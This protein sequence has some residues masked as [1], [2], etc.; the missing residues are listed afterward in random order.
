MQLQPNTL[1]QLDIRLY[2]PQNRSEGCT[3]DKHFLPHREF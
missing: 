2:M 3:A 1:N